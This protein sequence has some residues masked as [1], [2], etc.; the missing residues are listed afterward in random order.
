MEMCY[1]MQINCLTQKELTHSALTS[2]QKTQ[3]NK[4]QYVEANQVGYRNLLVGGWKLEI[5]PSYFCT[6][7]LLDNFS[8]I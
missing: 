7:E 2:P 1:A 4:T 3:T 5:F 6:S 8:K